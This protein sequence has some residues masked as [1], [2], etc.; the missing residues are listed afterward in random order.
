MNPI[1][2]IIDDDLAVRDS[3]SL[4]FKSV[5]L[6]SKHFADASL[7]LSAIP[8]SG[9][10]CLVLDVRMPGMSGLDLMEALRARNAMLPAIVMTGHAD[11]PMAVRAMKA[12]AEDFLE[13]PFNNQAMIDA[14]QRALVVRPGHSNASAPEIR[15]RFD[16]LTPREREVMALVVEGKANKVI[17]IELGLS[18]R[19]VELHRAHVMDKMEARSL[20]ALI[21][22]GLALEAE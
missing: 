2:C 13:K 11:V 21:R 22:M 17:G 16:T 5:G 9:A 6:E 20:A 18:Q 1:I 19:T 15:A 3:L 10:A 8:V 7:Y 14:V 4:L 12:G